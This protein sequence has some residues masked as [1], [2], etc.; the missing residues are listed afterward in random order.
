MCGNGKNHGE[1]IYANDGSSESA[2]WEAMGVVAKVTQGE[3]KREK[4]R[5]LTLGGGNGEEEPMETEE[6][7]PEE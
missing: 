5:E 2:V 7:Q 6:A 1:A 4:Q 3:S